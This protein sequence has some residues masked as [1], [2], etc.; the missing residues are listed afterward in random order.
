MQSNSRFAR[1]TVTP[2]VLNR[3]FDDAPFEVTETH[4]DFRQS[5]DQFKHSV[6]RDLE[7]L[8]NTRRDALTE[9][10]G[11]PELDKSVL[12]YGLPDFSNLSATSETDRAKIRGSI[13]KTIA[14]FEPRLH[15]VQVHLRVQEGNS[16]EFG[17]YIEAMLQVDPVPEPVAFDAVL[18]VATQLYKIE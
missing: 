18:E 12:A 16:A 11:W 4:L 6:A 5:L 13:E 10:E 15:Q 17:F 1:S 3:L 9:I 7:G 14:L 2:S 8:L